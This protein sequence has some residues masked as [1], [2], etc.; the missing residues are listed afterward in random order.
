MVDNFTDFFYQNDYKLTAGT[1]CQQNTREDL[2]PIRSQ[3]TQRWTA[4]SMG[5]GALNH[6]IFV[7]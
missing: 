2:A 5:G 1:K 7:Y 4:P 3:G 6:N